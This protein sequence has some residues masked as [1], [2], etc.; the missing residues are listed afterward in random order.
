MRTPEDSFSL[1]IDLLF[2]L[3]KDQADHK[4][5]TIQNTTVLVE[6]ERRSLASERRLDYLEK[7]AAMING[8]IKISG[9]ILA[10]AAAVLG[11]VKALQ[12]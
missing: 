10:L 9:G 1:I 6:H 7:Q 2:D 5:I 3:K 8:F 4:E 12:G 11:I